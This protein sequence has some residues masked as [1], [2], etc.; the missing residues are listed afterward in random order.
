MAAKPV[1]DLTSPKTQSHLGTKYKKMQIEKERLEVA[2]RDNANLLRKM[3]HIMHTH[4][5]VDHHHTYQ[6][7]SLNA[8]KRQREQQQ[9]SQENAAILKRLQDVR[10][11]Y[12]VSDWVTD[13]EKK[14]L[15]TENISAYPT[16]S[17]VSSSTNPGNRAQAQ[18]STSPKGRVTPASKIPS[19]TTTP[20]ISIA[21]HKRRLQ[22]RTS[23]DDDQPPPP[24][25]TV[26]SPS[27]LHLQ[28]EKVAE[29][30]EDLATAVIKS[31]N[32]QPEKHNQNSPN[33]EESESNTTA[34]DDHYKEHG[35]QEQ[36][37]D[38]D[39]HNTTAADQ[40]HEWLNQSSPGYDSSNQDD[41][42]SHLGDHDGHDKLNATYNGPDC[43]TDHDD[44]NNQPLHSTI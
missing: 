16:S 42:E 5:Y 26:S 14:E 1:V 41:P 19:R 10:P 21:K 8:S 22:R 44:L 23:V 33:Q 27:E 36:G 20:S 13:W 24:M 35:N 7:H 3:R 40:D 43:A 32:D 6:H 2:Q 11:M 29:A 37:D 9:L 17:R 15:L 34:G 39:D 25:V 30:L 38:Q 28:V 12:R 18:G 31:H 4:G